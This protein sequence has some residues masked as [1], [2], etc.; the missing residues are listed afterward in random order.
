MARLGN[1]RVPDLASDVGPDRNVLEVRIAA[2]QAPGRGDRLV[3]AG[4]DAARVGMNERRKR[5]DVG[6]LQFLKAPPLEDQLGEL[7]GERELLED[8]E[9]RRLRLG[10]RRPPNRLGPHAEPVEENLR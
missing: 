7:V 3:E 5:V 6:A 8:L 4:V 1:E 2:A 9:C 10:L